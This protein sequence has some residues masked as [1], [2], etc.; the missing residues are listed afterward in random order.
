[1]RDGVA[2][3]RRQPMGAGKGNGRC[4]MR[5]QP[6]IAAV[7]HQFQNSRHGDAFR[8]GQ[9]DAVWAEDKFGFARFSAKAV[10]GGKP[11]CGN[12]IVGRIG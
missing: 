5:W 6:L 7:I 12:W 1:M 11:L 9:N 4:G 8:T 3:L 2:R 10:F